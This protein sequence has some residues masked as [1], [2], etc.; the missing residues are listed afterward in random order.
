MKATG[1]SIHV[2][3]IYMIL[4]PGLGLIVIPEL[5]LEFFQLSH[6]GDIWLARM[7]GLL[8]LAIGVYY[9]FIARYKL[10]KLYILTVILRYVAAAFMIGLW[11]AGEVGVAILMFAAVDAFGATWTLTMMRNERLTVTELD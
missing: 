10:C 2:F 6:G 3:G 7:V 11:V 5:L 8:A 9:Y 1:L 4:I